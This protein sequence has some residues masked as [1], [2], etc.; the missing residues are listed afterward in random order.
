MANDLQTISDLI[1]DSL[2]IAPIEVSDLLKSSPLIAALAMEPSSN[3]TTHKYVKE[4]G[5]PVVGF[6]AANAGRDMTSSQDTLV[7]INLDI[8]DFSWMV[9]QA[10]ANAWRK[11]G[12]QAYIARE[13]SRLLRQTLLLTRSKLSTAKSVRAIAP[14][15]TVALLVSPASEM[16]RRWMLLPMQW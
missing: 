9:D 4:T 12:A 14:V 1:G 16:L 8:L 3:G 11:G 7:T 10:V 13:C 2:D 6:R 15:R 5:A